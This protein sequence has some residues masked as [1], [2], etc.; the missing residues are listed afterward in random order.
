M[1]IEA[2]RKQRNQGDGKGKGKRQG[3]ERKGL[4]KVVVEVE[5]SRRVRVLA[6]KFFPASTLSSRQDEIISSDL[7]LLIHHCNS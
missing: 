7:H 1:S 2:E 3:Q 6:Q 4:K 5:E